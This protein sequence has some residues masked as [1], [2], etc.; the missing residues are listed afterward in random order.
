MKKLVLPGVITVAVV[1]AVVWFFSSQRPKTGRQLIVGVY[2]GETS[3]ACEVDFPDMNVSLKRKDKI[4]WESEDNQYSIVFAP[5]GTC[6]SSGNPSGVATVA[7]PAGKQSNP[8]QPTKKGDYCY[9]VTTSNGQV[10]ADPGL[11]VKD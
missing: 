3:G 10:C 8:L 2:A 6:T 7:V 11:H 5:S 9:E 1:A 4:V